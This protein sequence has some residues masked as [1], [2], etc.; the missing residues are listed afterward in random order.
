MCQAVSRDVSTVGFRPAPLRMIR[1]LAG[2]QDALSSIRLWIYVAAIA[3]RIPTMGQS[4][5]VWHGW[6]QTQTAYTARIFRTEGIDLLR[7]QVPVFG[8]P[9][10]LVY[11]LPLFQAMASGVASL[12]V[13]LEHALRWTSLFWFAVTALLLG[14]ILVRIAGRRVAVAAELVFCSIPS[15][16]SGVAPRSLSIWLPPSLLLASWQHCVG[17][18][19][20]VGQPTHCGRS[21]WHR[22]HGQSHVDDGVDASYGS[23]VGDSHRDCH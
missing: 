21:R 4:L 7:P 17:V 10:V 15:A 13:G 23:L 3:L 19:A 11:E 8:R 14:S 18:T 12:G 22:F 5:T 6:R 1:L 2:L 9:F 16:C 20:V